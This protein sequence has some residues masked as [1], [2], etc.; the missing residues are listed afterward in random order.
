MSWLLPLLLGVSVSFASAP[1]DPDPTYPRVR[2]AAPLVRSLLAD[3]AARSETMR[4]LLSRI[5]GSDV[6]VYIELTGSAQIP[7]ARTKLVAAAAGVRFLRIGINA[8]VPF[9]NLG[10][11]LAHE[12]QHVLEI[13]D[14]PRAVSEDGVRRLYERI[15]RDR[16]GDRYETDAAQ[17][18][19]WV[20]RREMSR[21]TK[22]GG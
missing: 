9:A 19:E 1:F 17:H 2:P 15:G 11:L 22:I 5:A 13:A 12:L 16:G 21:V 7:I 4:D 8:G 20:V 18:V 6:I 14:D 3:A 10:P